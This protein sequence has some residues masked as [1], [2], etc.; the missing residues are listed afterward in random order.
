MADA[1]IPHVK[2]AETDAAGTAG[3]YRF[4]ATALKQWRW[5][6]GGSLFRRNRFTHPA[7]P[8]YLPPAVGVTM[9]YHETIMNVRPNLRMSKA[10]MAA[11][12]PSDKS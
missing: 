12:S 2:A 11:G 7:Q 5:G 10:G 3:G 6:H 1:G 9:T 4:D 8:G